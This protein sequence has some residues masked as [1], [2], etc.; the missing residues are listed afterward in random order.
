MDVSAE[1]DDVM[2]A[3]LSAVLPDNRDAPPPA[4]WQALGVGGPVEILRI[5]TDDWQAWRE[6][7]LRSLA[8]S[9]DA[10]G[11]TYDREIAFT[12][13]DWRHRL[14][15][16]PRFLVVTGGRSV[17]L[18]GGF[19]LP[20][21]L[22]VF[23]LWTDPAHRRLGHSLSILDAV[24]GWGRERNLPVELHVNVA[25]PGAR[26]AYERY[27]FVGTG[28]LEPLRPGSDQQIELMRLPADAPGR[29]GST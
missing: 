18:G 28:E 10:F 13:A 8:E 3:A 29:R 26:A 22:M 7:R 20:P 1:L 24:A 9:P 2:T 6:T 5:Q 4:R 14:A 25:N 23:G 11:S 21:G 27:G 19:P 17:A 12:E 15:K 16:G